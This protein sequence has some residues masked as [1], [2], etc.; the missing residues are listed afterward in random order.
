MLKHDC[1]VCGHGVFYSVDIPERR[2][3]DRLYCCRACRIV[4]CPMKPTKGPG[5][6]MSRW[7]A[8]PDLPGPFDSAS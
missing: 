6:D 7:G 5:P 8:L 2:D 3:G 1:P 4:I